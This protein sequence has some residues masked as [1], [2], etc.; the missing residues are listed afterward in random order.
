MVRLV[1]VLERRTLVD[2]ANHMNGAAC[3]GILLKKRVQEK[4]ITLFNP[5]CIPL[6]QDT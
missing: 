2:G 4:K 5:S 6:N 1:V 3:C